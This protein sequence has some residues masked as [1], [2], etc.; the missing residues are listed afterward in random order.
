MSSVSLP[1]PQLT[2]TNYSNWRFRVEI[3]LDK[4]GVSHV[5]R[6]TQ[7]EYNELSQK[8]MLAFDRSDSKAKG[9]IVQC[10][11]DQHL[12]Y[13]KDAK[14]ALEML[15]SLKNIFER[16]SPLAKLYIMKRLLKMKCTVDELQEHFMKVESLL[17][18]L[19]GAGANLDESDKVCYLLL[20]MPE[21]YDTVITAIETVNTGITL[22]FVKNRLLDAEL[23][24]KDLQGPTE[25]N[26][27]FLTKKNQKD[28]KCYGCGGDHFLRDC[29][30]K[31]KNE[32]SSLSRGRRNYTQRKGGKFNRNVN[33]RAY[34][35][36]ENTDEKEI[37][38][39]S[40]ILNSGEVNITY[41]DMKINFVLDSG[42]TDHLVTE[43]VEELMTDVRNLDNEVKIR[44]ANGNFLIA[45]KMGTLRVI[46]KNRNIRFDAL[47][48]QN[49]TNNLLSVKRLN[50]RGQKVIF[51]KNKT[52]IESMDGTIINC[53][54]MGKLYIASFE[55]Q[56]EVCNLVAT[57]DIWHRRLGHISECYMKKMNL[58]TPKTTCS[59]CR[60]A[61]GTREPFE[62]KQLP[63]SKSVGELLHSDIGGPIRT[64]TLNDERYYQTIIDDHSHFVTVYLLRNKSEAPFNLMQ[65]IREM[66][67][68]G[69]VCSRIRMDQGG[70]YTS[71]ELKNFC[72]Q[73]GIKT[74]YT[75]AYTPQQNG[76]SERANRTLLDKVR[77]MFTETNLPR[78]LW[79]EAIQ[80]AAYQLNRSPTAALQGKIPVSIFYSKTDLSKL[81]VFGSKVW[82]VKIPNSGDK[83]ESR[84]TPMRMVGYSANGYRLWNP[85]TNKI[86]ISRDVKFDEND[87]SYQESD[88]H[89]KNEENYVIGEPQ[90]DKL[91]DTETTSRRQTKIPSR[92]NDYELYHVYCLLTEAENPKDYKEAMKIGN[93]WQ[94]AISKELMAH[95]NYGTWEPAILP[96][97][98]TAIDTRWVFRTKQ[99][100]VKKARLVAKGYQEEYHYNAYAP[101]ARYQTIRFF[102]SHALEKNWDIKQFDIPTAFL[103]GKL[104]IDIFIK[105]PEGVNTKGKYNS[106]KLK[107]ALYGLREAP[108][109][110]N[111][112]F[113]QFA[114]KYK[115]KRSKNDFCLYTGDN[116]W[117]L[118]W[119]DDI[120]VTGR[121]SDFIQHKLELEFNAK[122][123]GKLQNFLGM[124]IIERDHKWLIS[125]KK[126]INKIIE[127]FN[128]HECKEA[129]TPMEPNFQVEDQEVIKVPYREIIGSLLYIATISRPD[130]AYSVI[131]LSRFLEKPT[132]Q[133]WNAARRIVR[134]LKG[135]VNLN[136]TYETS[137]E[138]FEITAYTDAD[139]GSDQLDRKSVSGCA[140]FLN[141]NLVTWISKKQ[142]V[143]A[144]SSCES[145]YLASAVAAS[146]L[147]YLK[148]ICADFELNI[149]NTILLI[150]NQS[151]LKQIES[152]ENS[153]RSKHVDIKAHFIKDIVAKGLIKLSFVSTSENVADIFTKSLQREKFVYFR[154]MLNV[155]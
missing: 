13:I 97:G 29:P 24:L 74:E 111:E 15:Q 23:K 123:L 154:N 139:W 113:Q 9:T 3:L 47:I 62:S 22:E 72:K 70:E 56:E 55:L 105:I 38:F 90:E 104:N 76:V 88:N 67:A 84:A 43:K 148:G 82:V 60:E 19:E 78:S 114:E 65:Y 36:E 120:I 86:I 124:E 12:E 27:V 109:L 101:V 98:K 28:Y 92:F 66:K 96:E 133:V 155:K 125:Q 153:K 85:Q 53:K 141:K 142:N 18:E 81:R 42:A 79:G 135:T 119:V 94:D 8:D 128:L 16:K 75:L 49:L 20:T 77:A 52:F 30:E 68:K 89:M 99:C 150:D 26:T 80:C 93:G 147:L 45:K 110:W 33:R 107:K 83:L 87:T 39:I 151:A 117:L 14:T 102:I 140:I 112:R 106:L 134:Y 48:V 137:N 40:E 7:D 61:K 129:Q 63:R 46:Y 95:E 44:V 132:Q 41:S 108:R 100:G 4:E 50:E 115:L 103:N 145:E 91:C 35:S 54:S 59:P 51:D 149:S 17:R 21:K 144:Q 143:V 118:I 138:N 126:L 6:T 37:V 152:F 2:N 136:L 121:N 127:K 130:I 57:G 73:K 122:N 34:T 32:V 31:N 69:F 58:P 11:S 25:R 131:F 146:E 64:P 10:M 71:T 1:F 116:V 5:L